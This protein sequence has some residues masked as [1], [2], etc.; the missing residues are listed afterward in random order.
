[1]RKIR[2]LDGAIGQ[3]LVNR[4]GGPV[5]TMWATDVLIH[6]PGLVYQLHKDYFDVG[7][8]I[9][10]T[11]TYAV[12]QDRLDYEHS[13]HDIKPLWKSAIDAAVK[14]RD[15]NTFGQVA[16]SIGPLVGSYLPEL[17]PSPLEAEKAYSPIV[18]ALVHH[19]D[20]LLI[21]TMSSVSQAEGA[22][23]AVQNVSIPVW[24]A[25]TVDDFNGSKLRSGE[26]LEKIQPLLNRYPI[27]ALLINCSRPEAVSQSI[28]IIKQ[29]ELPFGAY[30]NGFS[31][32]ND[33]YKKVSST[34]AVLQKRQDLSN[35]KYADDVLT[36]I[37]S[38][39]TIVGG[40]CEIGP[41]A[42]ATLAHRLTQS[43]YTIV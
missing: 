28:P 36:W 32:I 15:E 24:L 5:S 23:R 37:E 14:A 19:V 21:E 4:F 7:A 40:C 10:T 31:E 11:N 30:A 9:A 18:K 6:N 1:M 22:L 41:T 3:E 2:L 20:L 17:C 42:I 27:D 12:L 35:K 16:G 39:A 33:E 25:V 34:V 13:A 38:G 26:A 8:T 29:F 43:G